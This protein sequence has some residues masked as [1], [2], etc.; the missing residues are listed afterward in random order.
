MAAL[1]GRSLIFF[2]Q[3]HGS[4]SL[5]RQRRNYQ[6]LVVGKN[7]F[8]AR[9]NDFWSRFNFG[10]AKTIKCDCSVTRIPH[11]TVPTLRG[12]GRRN[13]RGYTR[14][15]F[16]AGSANVDAASRALYVFAIARENTTSTS[17][18]ERAPVLMLNC[19]RFASTSAL[20]NDRLTA[21]SGD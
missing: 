15:P 11:P 7:D 2:G 10:R 12:G 4:I 6:L 8:F 14:R 18:P 21:A 17:V 19:A 20:V 16:L 9:R 3:L 1:L 13:M 5:Y